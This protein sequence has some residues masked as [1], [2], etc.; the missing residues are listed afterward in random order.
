MQSAS[1]FK[2]TVFMALAMLLILP[3]WALAEGD[4][5]GGGQ[6]QPLALLTS[7]PADG[8]RD[9]ARD[10]KIKLSF[11]KNVVNMTVQAHNRQCITITQ[12]GKTVPVDVVMADD[13]VQPE[14]KR[15][16]ILV[17]RSAL[18]PGTKYTVNIAA[19]L[20]AKNGS[21][22]VQPV[23]ISF[24]TAGAAPQEQL[25]Q[26][27]A[28]SPAARE[29]GLP[30][31]EAK[32][33]TPVNGETQSAAPSDTAAPAPPVDDAQ[34]EASPSTSESAAQGNP[35]ASGSPVKALTY[36]GIVVLLG[37]GCLVFYRWKRK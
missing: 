24:T 9:V 29:T 31:A 17:P 21:T 10:T 30:G 35:E 26:N 18:L 8:A 5:S 36:G 32:E 16:I 14:G 27:S 28:S 4:G 34:V 1:K 37:A 2:L 19:G 6:N 3:F 7:S 33:P 22:M 20:Q 15:D 12:G 11:N 13:Q 23:S 25:A